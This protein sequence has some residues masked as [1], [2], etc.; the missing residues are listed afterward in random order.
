MHTK[1]TDEYN[2]ILH[3]LW[4]KTWTVQGQPLTGEQVVMAYHQLE[5]VEKR[6]GSKARAKR[7]LAILRKAGLVSFEDGRWLRTRY[8]HRQETDETD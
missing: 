3:K 6:L 7:A 8:A 5:S 2:A 4:F 1:T